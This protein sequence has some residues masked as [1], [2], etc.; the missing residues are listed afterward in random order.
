MS[1]PTTDDALRRPN[2]MR[3]DLDV[4]RANYEEI[5]RRSGDRRVVASV[6]ADAYGHG[7]VGVSRTLADAGCDSL[8]TG[9]IGDALAIK[10]AGIDAEVV[11]FGGY[12]PDQIPALVGEGLVPTVVDVAGA[13]AA[14]SASASV[15]VKVD[16]GLGRLGVPVNTARAVIREMA[17]MPGLTI[18]G[19]YTHLPFGDRAGREWAVSKGAVFTE[20]LDGLA[21]DGIRPGFTQMWG[22]SGLLAALPD[23]TNAVCVG[24]GLYG[25]S[26]YGDPSLTDAVLPSVVTEIGA[27]LI[28]V[29]AHPDD[30]A[31]GGYL[32]GGA[33]Q[34]GVIPFGVTDGQR[35]I[36]AHGQGHAL[37]RG[38][39]VP[40]LGT[41]LEHTVLDL[42]GVDAAVGDRVLL[43]GSDGDERITLTEWASSAGC[44]E[45]DAVLALS[46]RV[47]RI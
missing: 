3:V 16:A 29:A 44:S 17:A 9:H 2:W 36:D 30:A 19:I 34:V 40:M 39:R 32:A 26:P 6:K 20:L 11:L 42:T 14:A 35:R 37:V 22:S 38:R 27:R 21:R 33:T 31:A 1:A 15:Y 23:A 12:T 28:H 5:V 7:V 47:A 4:L 13:A 46:G 24:H 25:L 8:W 10:A 18:A 45:L 43:V 41:S